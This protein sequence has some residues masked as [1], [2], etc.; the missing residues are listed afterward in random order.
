MLN[1]PSKQRLQKLANTAQNLF[2]E[3]ALLV[4][5]N[6][7]LFKLNKE[8]K[9]R[10]STRSTVIGKAK[11][12]NYEDIIEAKA[13]RDAKEAAVAKGKPGR[14]RKASAQ[15][16]GPAKRARKSE[17][18]VAEEEIAALEFGS[19]CFVLQV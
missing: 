10:K 8:S 1:E 17:L 3:R 6:Q 16:K 13:K 9:T 7:L 18:E 12:M 14:K 2:A 15:V 5:E 4:D 19:H 11:V